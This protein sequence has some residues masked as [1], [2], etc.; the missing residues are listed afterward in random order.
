MDDPSNRRH[1]R[2]GI[3]GDEF[4]PILTRGFSV[5]SDEQ[6]REASAYFFPN[7]QSPQ[8]Q[9]ADDTVLRPEEQSTEEP[10]ESRSEPELQDQEQVEEDVDGEQRPSTPPSLAVLASALRRACF[11]PSADSSTQDLATRR[12]RA[13]TDLI[14]DPYPRNDRLEPEPSF[15][16]HRVSRWSFEKRTESPDPDLEPFPTYEESEPEE[17][18]PADPSSKDPSTSLLPSSPEPCPEPLTS[19]DPFPGAASIQILSNSSREVENLLP[20]KNILLQNQQLL[21]LLTS[22]LE[23]VVRPNEHPKQHLSPRLTL[24]ED[25]PPENVGLLLIL[26]SPH[27]ILRLVLRPGANGVV[28]TR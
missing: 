10:P 15:L 22:F 18:Y 16:Q 8:E 20:E 4:R 3:Y 7:V 5:D 11:S 24:L 14:G 23:A 17:W 12:A 9:G 19:R 2:R 26:L 1:R 25:D 28:T 21:L 27:H 6:E 13:Y